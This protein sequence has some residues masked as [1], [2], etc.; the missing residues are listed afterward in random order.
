MVTVPYLSR[1]R[2]NPLRA[3]ARQ[4]LGNP[5]ALHAAVLGGI[6]VQPVTERVLWRV[7]SDDPHRPLL[8]VLTDSRP[9]WNHLVEQ[10]GWPDADGD[11][12]QVRDYAPLLARIAVGREFAFRLTANPVQCSRTPTKRT[13]SQEARARNGGLTRGYRLGHRTVGH[14]LGWLLDRT[15]GWGFTI[16]DAQTGRPAPG[17]TNDES[18]TAAP[19]KDVRITAR[20]RWCFTRH[21]GAPPVVLH[22]ATYAGQLIVTDADLLR[23]KLL[24][25]IGPGKAY[26]CG[27]L[28]LATASHPADG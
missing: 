2:I 24:A 18:L 16:P 11:H 17:M 1:I 8:Y 5:Q 20:A 25:G 27:L 12:A 9:D 7:D 13:T 3:H 14:Q 15:T 6:A 28:T 23:D 21:R 26:G 19:A 22:T 4:L 10:A